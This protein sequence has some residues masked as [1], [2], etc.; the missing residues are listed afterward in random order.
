MSESRQYQD[1]I[2]DQESL[3]DSVNDPDFMPESESEDE[4][5]SDTTDTSEIIPLVQALPALS[6]KRKI[7][8][9]LED[10]QTKRNKKEE[11]Q[12][13]YQVTA[14]TENFETRSSGVTV[15]KSNNENGIKWDK[16]QYCLFCTKGCTNIGKHY[17]K[18]HKT[19]SEIK[20]ILCLPLK[21]KERSLELTR[22]RNA[23][24]YKHNV[25]VLKEGKGELV[26]FARNS[27]ETKPEDYLP[28]ESCLGF[29]LKGSLW[30]HKQVCPLASKGQKFR[31][32]QADAALLLPA[33]KEIHK[34]LKQNVF[35]KMIGDNVT[36]AARNDR[37]ILKI[38]E[39]LYQKHG[40][41]P[42]L[43]S[44]I[45]QKMRECGRFL[46]CARDIDSNI[47]CLNDILTPEKFVVAVKATKVLCNFDEIRN[48]YANPFLALKLGHLLK[49]CAKLSKSDALM[50]GNVEQG[51]KADGF[52][53]LCQNEW[54]DEI[55]SSA[56]QTL[57][58]N[59]MNKGHMLPL[60]EDIMSL[61][62][63]LSQKSESLIES[64]E[65]RFL[66][67]EWE[68][69]N[70][71]TL[72]HLVMFNRRRGGETQRILVE[73]YMSRVKNTESPP[74]EVTDALSAT[75]RILLKTHSR[76]EIRGKKGRTVPVLLTQKV[77]KCIDLLLKWRDEA[78]VSKENNYVFARP[79]Y[80]SLEPLR[81]SD[82]LRY[83]AKAAGLTN[84]EHITSTRLRK[85]V[86]TVAQVLSLSKN[87]LEIMA[88]FMGHDITVHRSFYRLPQETLQVARMGR[89]LTAFNNG[90]I[91][92]YTGKS[93]DDIPLCKY[94]AFV[95][96]HC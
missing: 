52:L 91:G 14:T 94:V 28:C 75:E 32:V 71:I 59:K 83:F 12:E 27:S 73:T 54:T 87:D 35:S 30:R 41:L 65:D 58:T 16:M 70:Q 57:T 31:R 18:S 50:Y 13:N 90:T 63:Y 46:I 62:S 5:V 47:N 20:K 39:K 17:L 61:Q 19:E 56:I 84:P 78:G 51:T 34:G 45:S 80:S 60:S 23:G 67:S 82:V 25:Q 42:H 66:K 53:T 26:V 4:R 95:C 40:H 92:Q 48:S 3:D 49:K 93:I 88:S 2:S 85:H 36:I 86:A 44:H 64:L 9:L 89:L 72:A 38:G 96:V 69:L 76:V 8:D 74:K 81:S 6:R 11:R 55:S 68:L 79:N 1:Q 10:G 24:N 33:S 21:S 43:F 7:F 15:Q 22:V 37:I 77:Q 29:F